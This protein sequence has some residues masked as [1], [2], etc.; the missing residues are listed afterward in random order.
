[1]DAHIRWAR[2]A[3]FEVEGVL[4]RGVRN[5]VFRA[6]HVHSN[7]TVALKVFVE[8]VGR[9]AA[10]R[11]G[12]RSEA[13]SAAAFDHPSIVR[14]YQSGEFRGRT[15]YAFEYV[16]GGS[17]AERYADRPA[18]L[19][20]AAALVRQMAEAVQHA[21]ALGI[22]HRA[23]KPSNV[24]VTKDGVPKI[25]NFG[26]GPRRPAPED[27][28][29]G[30]E[31][32]G[33][34]RIPSYTA[35]ELMDGKDEHVG[36]AVDIYALGAILYQML[37]GVP[38]VS[39]ASVAETLEQVRTGRPTAPSRFNRDIPPSLDAICMKCLE[40]EPVDRY[41]SADELAAALADFLGP[42]SQPPAFAVFG[43]PPSIPDYEFMDVLARGSL[44]VVYAAH[45]QAL[46]RMVAL[47]VF[48]QHVPDYLRAGI[49]DMARR[50]SRMDHPNL[51]PVYHCGEHDARFYVCMPLFTAGTLRDARRD[52][53]W[54]IPEATRLMRT[55][56][57]AMDYAHGQG[58]VHGNLKPS[59]V[60]FNPGWT[61]A[62]GG[63]LPAG[64]LRS[65]GE[66][67][68]VSEPAVYGTPTYMAPEQLSGDT[69]SVG[70]AT[71]VYA[72]GLIL[73]ELLA[74]WPPFR[75][76]ALWDMV[77]Q[78][79]KKAPEPTRHRNPDVPPALD[80]ICLRCLAKRPAD[81]YA[82]AG[83]LADEL[84]QF[85][86]GEPPVVPPPVSR[87]GRWARFLRRLT[88]RSNRSDESR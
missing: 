76:A 67:G 19:R 30:Y 17:L 27:W 44:S 15:F 26:L 22:L 7:R 80:A 45:N 35:P 14:M 49:A 56:A 69:E 39:G 47:K 12:F 40:K 37:T 87:P 57:R 28:G 68:T 50:V 33:I 51:V 42:K 86:A 48:E 6:R 38:P 58:V 81:R 25:T 5:F 31:L 72:L 11:D 23:L 9:E 52:R 85:L 8:P 83:A 59:K 88:G 74:G 20:D 41:A 61:P 65:P 79:Q 71:D 63:F 54:A 4:A 77:A 32:T 70:L 60:L 3:G 53:R 24:L 16:A 13:R 43:A 34:Q 2:A 84:D 29:G 36:P 75:A 21:H 62:I 64:V 73:Y 10:V 46:G 66:A 55:L 78:V 18:P 82:S 1:V